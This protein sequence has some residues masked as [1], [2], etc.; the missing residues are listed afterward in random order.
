MIISWFQNINLKKKGKT[1]NGLADVKSELRMITMEDEHFSMEK[2]FIEQHHRG[3]LI[4]PN[5][6]EMLKEKRPFI[7]FS[8]FQLTHEFFKHFG[9]FTDNDFKVY[10]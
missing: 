2:E 10:V 4:N 1:V 3:E 9:H 6:G 5:I 7:L 8:K